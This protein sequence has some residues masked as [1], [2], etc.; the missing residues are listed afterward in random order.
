[1]YKY[2][3]KLRQLSIGGVIKYI[4]LNNLTDPEIPL[5]TLEEQKEI[6]KILEQADSIHQKRKQTTDLLDE[7]LKSVFFEMFGDPFI[8]SKKLPLMKFGE[9]EVILD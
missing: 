7:Y 2:V 6:V 4:K 1:M 3:E 9:V 5:P 8:N